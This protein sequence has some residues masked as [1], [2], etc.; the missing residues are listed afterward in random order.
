[1]TLRNSAGMVPPPHVP[2]FK[3][4]LWKNS[5]IQSHYFNILHNFFQDLNENASTIFN[6]KLYK[7][8]FCLGLTN[9]IFVDSSKGRMAEKNQTVFCDQ[10]NS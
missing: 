10:I 5:R 6:G 7:L 9:A 3:H 2:L 8:M 4:Y 1:M